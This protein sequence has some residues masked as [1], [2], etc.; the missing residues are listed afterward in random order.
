MGPQFNLVGTRVLDGDF[1]AAQR[2]YADHVHQLLAW[3]G[4][5]AAELMQR[6][7]PAASAPDLLCLY[8]FGSAA[9]LAQYETSAVRQQAEADRQASWGRDGI[10]VVL[11]GPYQRLYRRCAAGSDDTADRWV[12]HGVAGS[13]SAGGI[14]TDAGSDAANAGA[15][16]LPTWARQQAAA[17]HARSVGDL[18]LYAASAGRQ[19][20]C[21][22]S[23]AAQAAE[24]A[25]MASPADTSDLAD[26]SN[27]AGPHGPWQARYQVLYR[28]QR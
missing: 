28:W 27:D 3:P 25:D 14:N 9:S 12:R 21:I 22:E 16:R 15:T 24:P 23:I 2:W 10:A 19:W 18:A 17:A 1:S 13:D 26:P 6:S 5:R 8:D 7:G 11:R 20:L 4:L